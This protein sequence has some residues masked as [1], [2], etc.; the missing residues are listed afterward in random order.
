[1][2]TDL[3]K[4]LDALRSRTARFRRVGLHIHSPD[5]HDWGHG[6]C[7]T[8]RN[9]RSRFDAA[10]GIGAYAKELR[11]HLDMAAVTDH[12]RCGF[13]SRVSAKVDDDD[14]F[15]VLPGMEVNFQPDAALG[16]TRI[17]LLVIFPERSTTHA[18]ER[19]FAGL[20]NIPA[21]DSS[22]TGQEEV[23][24]IT[25]GDWVER[26]HK[27]NGICIAAHV[28]NSLGVRCLFRQ[29]SEETL[30]LFS[31]ADK[32]Q[33][34]KESDVP[35]SLMRYLFESRLDA[36]EIAKSSY[37]PHYRWVCKFDGK[38]KWIPTV[39]TFDAHNVEGFGRS[40]RVTHIKMT[41]LG[42][43]GLKDA[44]SFPDTRIRFPD[45]LPSPPSPRL[46][47]IEVTGDEHSFFEDVTVALT[48]NLNCLI[49]AR[50]SGKST[51][52]EV[53]RYVFGYNRTL[54]TLDK[55]QNSIRD[56]QKS[57]LNGCLLR[58][59]Y[60]TS[61]GDERI[62]QATFDEKSD[63]ST[64][65]YTTTGEYLDVADVET[66]GEYPLRLFGWSEIETL[67][68]SPAH[69][70]DLLDRLIPELA[71]VLSRRSEIR[72]QLRANRGSVNK[73]VEHVKAAFN[74]S[75]GEIKR[76]K[77]FKTDFDK[78]NTPEV[79]E[80]F[81]ALDLAQN[82]H[83]VLQ[84]IKSN[85]S[86]LI[87]GFG[88]P[89]KLGVQN[90]L[91]A[92]L[93]G[94]DQSLRDWWLAEELQRLAVVA[95]EQDIQ[96]F[97]RQAI[98]RLRSFIVLVD[99]HIKDVDRE[100]EDVQS[101]LQ[102]EYASDTSKQKIAD[103]RANAEKRLR[104]VTVL[105]DNYEKAWKEMIV[106]LAERKEIADRLA[107]VQNEIAGI[108][109]KHNKTIEEKLNS[110]LPENMNVSIEF[111]AG[112]DTV[113]FSRAL[114]PLLSAANR[115]KAR[116][117]DRVVAA[118]YTPVS[119]ASMLGKGQLDD[120]VDKSA[121]IDE[122]VSTFTED[123]VTSISKDTKPFAHDEYANVN[124]LAEDGKCLE[125]VLDL[126]EV[127]WDDHETIL[128]NGGPVNEKSP[129]QRSS[130]MLPLIA[131][132]EKTPLVIDQPEDNLDKRL[133]GNVLVK[134]L[135]ELKEQRQI[136]VCTHDPNILVSGDSEQ[137]V[138]LEAESDHRGSV[139]LHGSIDNGDIVQTVLDLLE[140]GAEA[141]EARRERYDNRAGLL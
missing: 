48:E 120:L 67:G 71:P 58:V 9:D 80:L 108:R 55:L 93:T 128:L 23:T 36:V 115:Y 8:T 57:N 90:D 79:K 3:I 65:I 43:A 29:T 1:M 27:E 32:Q 129:G 30:K 7:D 46:L 44:F 63:Y 22:R 124:V 56:M 135:A 64:K 66:S 74:R 91:E 117:L 140:G 114:I 45:N 133:I 42:I 134:I 83:R 73:A 28:D 119:F 52:V 132:S 118:H 2:Y 72:N 82:K 102:K 86:M 98:E 78:L 54:S 131:L 4:K 13:A 97:V 138:V 53:L 84:Q 95:M 26:V 103:L 37:S 112:G 20:Q 62:L 60:R 92:I 31:D 14:E 110:F 12:M 76:F 41:H 16:C 81:A 59:I 127:N 88:D 61:S 70:R 49:G 47:G 121:T 6:T 33:L 10:N 137:V 25:L 105:R 125:A 17:H 11:E 75:D 113:G 116:C 51:L 136:I 38:N 104:H 99:Q 68:R 94:A 24:G 50:G 39:L 96:G 19:L 40:E 5:S 21:D 35:E 89:D 139:L 126:Q 122:K 15:V 18:I 106:V 77:E 101:K 34:E 85:A 100:I 130:A 87:E 109:A 107:G 111:V 141:F 69:Q 123:D